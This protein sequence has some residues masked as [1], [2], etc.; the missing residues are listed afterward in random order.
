MVW[1]EADYS[2]HFRWKIKWRLE[3]LGAQGILGQTACSISVVIYSIKTSFI[4]GATFMMKLI[5]LPLVFFVL[6]SVL[7]A[8]QAD[9]GEYV[10]QSFECRT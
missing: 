4:K 8:I 6:I 7:S 10:L 2:K 9:L 1:M 3:H 5:G